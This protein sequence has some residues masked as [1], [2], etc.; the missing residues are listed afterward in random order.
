[1]AVGRDFVR[2]CWDE[3]LNRWGAA[4]RAGRGGVGSQ[5]WRGVGVG[6]ASGYVGPPS[7]GLVDLGDAGKTVE[8]DR[9]SQRLM[10]WWPH[11]CTARMSTPCM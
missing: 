8:Q 7:E 5:G 2:V 4:G 10:S 6:G 11:M 9:L 1:M 3:L